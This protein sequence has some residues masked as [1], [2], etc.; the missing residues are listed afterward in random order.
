MSVAPPPTKKKTTVVERSIKNY[1]TGSSPVVKV[2]ASTAQKSDATLLYKG[3]QKK[4]GLS[5]LKSL[6]H[7]L[8]RT[9]SKYIEL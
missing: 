4:I 9:R 7:Y 8:K 3:E 1:G 6:L 5:K 2:D